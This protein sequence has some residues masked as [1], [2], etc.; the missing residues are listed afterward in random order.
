MIPEIFNVDLESSMEEEFE[1]ES[2]T[3]SDNSSRVSGDVNENLDFVQPKQHKRSISLIQ[4]AVLRNFQVSIEA[5]GQQ[6]I[7]PNT[8]MPSNGSNNS[9][10]G[11]NR[12]ISEITS[13]PSDVPDNRGHRRSQSNILQ[14]VSALKPG[15]LL[16]YFCSTLR[17]IFLNLV[18]SIS[19]V[20]NFRRNISTRSS[21]REF[22]AAPAYTA[23]S[24]LERNESMMRRQEI[25]TFIE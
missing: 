22:Y 21:T 6:N 7:R 1:E 11:Y 19:R 23:A 2:V 3:E 10:I 13:S 24:L 17:F 15:N 14:P 16:K 12:T 20:P 5:R 18:P 9:R 8:M 4:S 25:E